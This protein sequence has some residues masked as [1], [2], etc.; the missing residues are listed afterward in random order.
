MNEGY[1]WLL[2]W[3]LCEILLFSRPVLMISV[4]IIVIW[5]T[6]SS[7]TIGTLEWFNKQ[8][9]RLVS[10]HCTRGNFHSHIPPSRA[11]GHN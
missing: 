7:I 8:K 1:D 6:P 3:G 4:E 5:S 9:K 11:P 2:L 10:I